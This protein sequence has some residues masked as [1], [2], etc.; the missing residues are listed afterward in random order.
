MGPQGGSWQCR[1]VV[2]ETSR[3]QREGSPQRKRLEGEARR[4]MKNVEWEMQQQ[5]W[6]RKVVT[7][8]EWARG[9]RRWQ[10]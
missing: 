9:G 2:A 4:S 6:A 3:H 8:G 7:V 10:L 1:W 5:R